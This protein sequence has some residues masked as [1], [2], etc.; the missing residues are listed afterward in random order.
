MSSRYIKPYSPTQLQVDSLA[1]NVGSNTLNELN[2]SHTQSLLVGESFVSSKPDQPM[3]GLIVDHEGI[4]V[5]ATRQNRAANK[6]QYAMY[7]DGDAL[8]TGTIYSSNVVHLMKGGAITSGS[9]ATINQL[10]SSNY[11]RQPSGET[12]NIYYGGQLTLGNEHACIA[13]AHTLNIVA[14][15]DRTINHAQLSIQN[16][17]LSQLQI[18]ILGTGTES[19]TIFHSANPIEFHV[20]R[21]SNYFSGLYQETVTEEGITE[22]RDTEVPNYTKTN[23][24]WL[25]N[26][27]TIQP[28]MTIDVNGNV[29]IR[30]NANPPITYEV[31]PKNYATIVA[32]P[33][34]GRMTTLFPKRREPMQLHVGG[35]MFAS[36]ILVYDYD[37]GNACNIDTLY[38]RRTG[39]TVN[40]ENV[41]PG[42]FPKGYFQFQSNIAIGSG[43]TIEPKFALSVSGSG[44]ITSNLFVD[45]ALYVTDLYA[46]NNTFYEDIN[47]KKDVIVRQSLRLRGGLMVE[48]LEAGE[49]VWKHIQFTTFAD[50]G[51]SNINYFGKGITTPGRFGT[52]IG[53]NQPVNNQLVSTSAASDIFELELRNTFSQMATRVAYIGHP[54]PHA[55]LVRDC[56]LVIATP[57]DDNRNFN[58][59]GGKVYQNI[60]LYPGTDV[61]PHPINQP[62]VRSNNPPVLGAFTSHR[63][64]ILTFDP[65]AEL[66]VEGSILF[67][68]NLLSWDDT[69]GQ[70]VKLGKWLYRD[71]ALP[72]QSAQT[73]APYYKGIQYIDS[74]AAHVGIH[75]LP[76]PEYGLA[77][78]GKIK[79]YDGFYTSSNERILS[80]LDYATAANGTMPK[81]PT[82]MYTYGKVGIGITTISECVEIKNAYV[83]DTRLKLHRGAASPVAGISFADMST[84]AGNQWNLDMNSM[85]NTMD[86]SHASAL[87]NG[88]CVKYDGLTKKHTVIIGSNETVFD[89]LTNDA[90]AMTVAGNMTVLGD[91]KIT[92]NYYSKNTIINVSETAENAPAV[93]T[94][95]ILIGGKYIHIQPMN[96]MTV[97]YT[98]ELQ[99]V[100]AS[101]PI[102]AKLCVHQPD[103]YASTIA[104]FTA[105]GRNGMIEVKNSAGDIFKY[106]IYDQSKLAFLDGY[107]NPYLTFRGYSGNRYVGF[108]EKNPEAQLHVTSREQD[109]N[110]FLLRKVLDSDTS[111]S[112]EVLLQ[113]IINFAADVEYSNVQVQVPT[114]ALV[115]SVDP[116]TGSNIETVVNGTSNAIVVQA[117]AIPPRSNVHTWKI[118]GPSPYPDAVRSELGEDPQK[119]SFCYT[120]ASETNDFDD[121]KEVFTFTDN[122]CFGIGTT[123][124]KYALDIVR[125]GKSGS[126]RLYNKDNTP[127][128]QV[129]FQ[130][131]APDFGGDDEMDY[132]MYACSNEF[133]LEQQNLT[134]GLFRLL[135]FGSNG[136]V[137][138]RSNA[139]PQFE[140]NLQG[141]INVS[142]GFYLDGAPL[143]TKNSQNDVSGFD[144]HAVD[145]F[146]RPEPTQGGGVVINNIYPTCNLFHIFSGSDPNMV[147]YDS[148]FINAQ[149]Y[150]RVNGTTGKHVYRV[151][152]S[153]ESY[154]IEYCPTSPDGTQLLD[155]DA[156][157]TNVTWWYPKGSVGTGPYD[158]FIVDVY[159]DL[160]LKAT[161]PTIQFGDHSRIGVD[162]GHLS[163]STLSNVGINTTAPQ[164]QLHISSD[165]TTG[166][167]LEHGNATC[168]MAAFIAA[169]KNE[170]ESVFIGAH[171]NVSIGGSN[172][173]IDVKLRVNGNVAANAFAFDL[174]ANQTGMFGRS[175]QLMLTTL[176][177][178][179]MIVENTGRVTFGSNLPFVDQSIVSIVNDTDEMACLTLRQRASSNLI[180]VAGHETAPSSK[181]FI[182]NSG[183]VGIGF[184]KD[185]YPSLPQLSK[186]HVESGNATFNCPIIPVGTQDIGDDQHA[187][188]DVYVKGKI[189]LAAPSW[190]LNV[191]QVVMSATSPGDAVQITTNTGFAG[192]EASFLRFGNLNTGY[193]ATL[194]VDP[195]NGYS[196]IVQYDA[197]SRTSQ[198]FYLLQQNVATNQVAL[199]STT[200]PPAGTV[201]I[202][203]NSNI[204]AL[205]I[206]QLGTGLL[207]QGRSGVPCVPCINVATNGNIGVGSNVL[208]LASLHIVNDIAQPIVKL[209]QNASCNIMECTGLGSNGLVGRLV[210]NSNASVGINIAPQ[211]GLHVN[212]LAIFEKFTKFNSNVYFAMDTEVQGNNFVH[213]DST[214]DSDIRLKFDIQRIENAVEKLEKLNG[215]TFRKGSSINPMSDKR[216]TGL[217]AQEVQKVVPEVIYE[218][219]D[220]F[221]S[222][223]YGNMMGYVIEAIKEL[224]QEID[225]IKLN[226]NRQSQPTPCSLAR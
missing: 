218:K 28:S 191:P 21:D 105:S 45:Q 157:Y 162:N 185:Q 59:S 67:K 207:L 4:A 141:A 32:Q 25:S 179:R 82:R 186:F 190:T 114:T 96:Y 100:D 203:A 17:Q 56:S 95:D 145:V 60:Y 224:K 8:F 217:I 54:M 129:I 223:A 113:K 181:F 75:T 111:S 132:R 159:G 138:M 219:S 120:K 18:G 215:Y 187:W 133:I 52:G 83:G 123:D 9:L 131:G 3:Y 202:T 49:L 16:E 201:H 225:A 142:T 44:H 88:M 12:Q 184:G 98:Q 149:T 127:T 134:N 27:P 79:S 42:S 90:T 136:H 200:T 214:T 70:P 124:P 84:G 47:A 121:E 126:L 69:L 112:P 167:I 92:G 125:T 197:I 38:A 99:N 57:K 188:Q 220:G 97:G 221:L 24:W 173:D 87:D 150:Y 107:N 192:V 80:W 169:S 86:L 41:F 176:G 209:Q 5:N 58:H 117:I 51:L 14:S 103:P 216:C 130:S 226:L 94:D 174:H 77:V 46:Q 139:S 55:D 160:H 89:N 161:H 178:P 146:L 20:N 182:N 68:N 101:R 163:F 151:S 137:G 31:R 61:D 116:I 196:K 195:V 78:K 208:P 148:S 74:S 85:K 39:V 158:E 168:N 76:E 10:L 34:N 212:D 53:N 198:S 135:H 128:P 48:S 115:T 73:Q 147:V 6:N 109:S 50:R 106:G 93:A 170:S 91:V 199:G 164:G 155:S 30:T 119:L 37:S 62:I 29:G 140:L 143:F 118:K 205:L 156:G 19:P 204:P 33:Q 13:N 193:E 172:Q 11:W 211:V 26:M 102:S 35:S 175:N 166:F 65:Q 194:S 23:G 22:T 66:H 64:G 108:N 36:N 171:G 177:I 153:N 43:S 1:I 71:Y 180:F 104:S 122:G 222:L 183:A 110:M 15:A 152:M 154:G 40:A 144:I 7:V 189:M 210:V 81:R 165:Q 213:G 63:V 206:D 2:M 72:Q